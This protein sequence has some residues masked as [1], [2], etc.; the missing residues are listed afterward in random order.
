MGQ[1]REKR[2][3]KWGEVRRMRLSGLYVKTA[4]D[5]AVAGLEAPG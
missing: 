3:K 2:D 5:S 1:A 4:P